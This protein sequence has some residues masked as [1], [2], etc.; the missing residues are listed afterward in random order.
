M[1]AHAFLTD[2][3]Q[4]LRGHGYMLVRTDKVVRVSAQTMVSRYEMENFKDEETLIKLREYIDRQNLHKMA[5]ELDKA[6]QRTVETDKRTGN[7]IR[8]VDLKVILP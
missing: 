3:A 7:E 6:V 4:L 8:R 5:E 1:H 2:L